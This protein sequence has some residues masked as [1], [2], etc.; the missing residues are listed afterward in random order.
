[1]SLK[2]ISV[3]EPGLGRKIVEAKYQYC[4][5]ST[6]LHKIHPQTT[7]HTLHIALCEI[8][9]PRPCVQTGRRNYFCP[10]TTP[11]RTDFDALSKWDTQDKL[12]LSKN[13]LEF[14]LIP[15]SMVRDFEHLDLAKCAR[16]NLQWF[17]N[18]SNFNYF[19][20]SL[21][22]LTLKIFCQ[23]KL[24]TPARPFQ[25]ECMLGL[26]HSLWR[27]ESLLIVSLLPFTSRLRGQS[28]CY[29]EQFIISSI[30]T[31]PLMPSK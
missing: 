22:K 25:F 15:F 6:F 19:V 11:T 16:F 8:V 12:E 18:T 7:N 17:L 29:K 26:T 10:T 14:N 30:M 31:K 9:S 27:M 3:A 2:S 13:T 24:W 20:H 28:E 21:I 5:L 1:M 4:C 23:I